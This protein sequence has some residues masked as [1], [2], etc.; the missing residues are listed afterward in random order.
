[1]SSSG[2]MSSERSMK[3]K[4][5]NADLDSPP[6]QSSSAS[7]TPS[8]VEPSTK[9]S[10]AESPAQDRSSGVPERPP[11]SL[12][13]A[14]NSLTAVVAIPSSADSA[15][16]AVQEATRRAQRT[17]Q[18]EQ[19]QRQLK[20]LKRRVRARIARQVGHEVDSDG[21][22]ECWQSCRER[23]GVEAARRKALSPEE[24]AP[25]DF[26][27]FITP[28]I[29]VDAPGRVSLE[30][31]PLFFLQE[32][33]RSQNGTTCTFTPCTD[34][35]R[36]GD[37]RMTVAPGDNVWGSPSELKSFSFVYLVLPNVQPTL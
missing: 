28:R 16:A 33:P 19:T 29:E 18:E 13:N 4:V 34:R 7:S 1:M 10:S 5:D 3:R 15:N 2:N 23:D 21:E 25:E 22:K 20:S 8:A 30:H 27:T 11:S 14:P 31:Y 12:A 26:R 6:A 9:Q 24:R 36:P 17:K 35:I 37:Y 32:A